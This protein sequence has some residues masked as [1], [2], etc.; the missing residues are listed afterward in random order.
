MSNGRPFVAV[1]SVLLWTLS[2][3]TSIATDMSCNG[4]QHVQFAAAIDRSPL[5]DAEKR[6]LRLQAD[7]FQ[8]DMNRIIERAQP[9]E[10]KIADIEKRETAIA[11]IQQAKE[12]FD[13][14]PKGTRAAAVEFVRHNHPDLFERAQKGDKDA[15]FKFSVAVY[16]K[17][18][19]SSS[20]DQLKLSRAVEAR[21][22]R[23]DEFLR[24]KSE[25]QRVQSDA[26]QIE[27]LQMMTRASVP[28]IDA[29]RELTQRQL[30]DRYVQLAARDQ[31]K[32][33]ALQRAA[34]DVPSLRALFA[35]S[36]LAERLSK[37][38]NNI[39]TLQ[40]ISYQSQG[41]FD[42][43]VVADGFT[44]FARVA[45]GIAAT[46]LE[47]RL[48]FGHA[49]ANYLPSDPELRREVMQRNDS[50]LAKSEAKVLAGAL[51]KWDHTKIAAERIKTAV[52]SP[53]N[54]A[55][56]GPSRDFRQWMR[57]AGEGLKNEIEKIKPTIIRPEILPA[58]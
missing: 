43:R 11:A 25:D 53:E 34:T 10:V 55:S 12:L 15:N 37:G 54:L 1:V 2:P 29:E 31:D 17:F 30:S 56:P 8:S 28:L 42:D 16:E 18:M 5:S 3:S 26:H 19:E 39:R 7:R 41:V 22:F 47:A 20:F 35:A 36:G 21:L 57:E 4:L 51:Q 14:A 33:A 58:E 38:D 24:T 44:A 40:A 13:R 49:T 6:Q 45:K 52:P 23:N 50:P 48:D 46:N 9:L 27:K 32:T